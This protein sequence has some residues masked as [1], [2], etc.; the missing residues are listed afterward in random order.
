MKYMLKGSI[1]A[2]LDEKEMLEKMGIV[3]GDY[4]ESEHE[5][6]DCLIS[7]EAMS[8]LDRHWGEFFWSLHP[9]EDH[10]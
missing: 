4:N 7:D 3:L 6:Q 8:Q 1:A 5:F 2:S 10:H 9:I